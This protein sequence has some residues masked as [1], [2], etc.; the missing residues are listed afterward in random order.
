MTPADAQ[1]SRS[2]FF[3]CFERAIARSSPLSSKLC[4]R[5]EYCRQIQIS[6]AVASAG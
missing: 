4:F 2:P 6:S 3:S 5:Q 1:I